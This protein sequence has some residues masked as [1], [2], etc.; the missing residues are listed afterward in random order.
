M[1]PDAPDATGVCMKR[2]LKIYLEKPELAA[3]LFLLVLLVVV[4]QIRSDGVF[5]E[6][7]TTC[8]ACS[9]SCRR[10]GSSRSASRC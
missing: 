8:A 6:R 1:E 7:R 5:L 3:A 10:W 4:F 2:L 9:A